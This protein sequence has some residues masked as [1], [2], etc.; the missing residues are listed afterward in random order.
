MQILFLERKKKFFFLYNY[1]KE[2]KLKV[3]IFLGDG[4]RFGIKIFLESNKKKKH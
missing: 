4:E 3:V 1:S 2:I